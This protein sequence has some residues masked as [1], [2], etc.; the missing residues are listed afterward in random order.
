MSY[1]IAIEITV[2]APP[3]TDVHLQRA[4]AHALDHLEGRPG[5]G[6]T[7]VLG[8]DA[9]LQTLNRKFRGEDRPTDV[10]SFPAG[11]M[12]SL[13]GATD[14]TRYLGDIA[15]SVP[16][17]KRQAAQQGHALIEELQLLAIHGVLHLMGYDH[18][19]T[20]EKEAMWAQQNTVLVSLGLAHVQPTEDDSEH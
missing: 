8:S 5:D 10:L 19:T 18:T 12:P 3:D 4:V 14:L 2:D 17:A 20:A 6:L 13:P 9:D 1:E 11:D 7:I 15:I 16:L